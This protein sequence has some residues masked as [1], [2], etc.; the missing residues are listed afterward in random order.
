MTVTASS[1][2]GELFTLTLHLM[3]LND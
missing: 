1:F 2:T 3:A